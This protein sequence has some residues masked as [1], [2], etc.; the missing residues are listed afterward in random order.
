MN[1]IPCGENVNQYS[2]RVRLDHRPVDAESE[3]PFR[4]AV[5]FM[6]GTRI[7]S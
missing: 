5:T 7:V 6:A 4:E 1:K 2:A 3:L